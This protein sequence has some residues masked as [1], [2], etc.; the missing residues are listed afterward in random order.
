M[1][2]EGWFQAAIMQ[3]GGRD[4]PVLKAGPF[5]S[6]ITKDTYTE[7]GYKV[8][9][10]Q[11]VLSGNLNAASYY[12][13]KDAYEK[14]GSCSVQAGDILITMM[15][16]VG[17]IL[18]VP[19][20]AEPGVINP[21]L[22][23]ISVDKSRVYPNFLAR[24]LRTKSIQRLLQRRAHGGTMPGLNAKAIGSIRLDFPSLPEQRRIAEILHI[25]DLG[26]FT[27]EALI[28]NAKAHKKALMQSLL[29]SQRRL[30]GFSADWK[31]KS[32]DD[33][34]AFRRG[35]G[36]SKD[37][38]T[39][40]GI[41]PCILYGELYTRYP[42]VIENVVGRT[43]SN[44]G[45]HSKAGDILIPASTTTTG[46]DLANATA[47]LES[48][49]LLSGDINVLRAKDVRQSAPFFA[50]L[51]THTMKYKIASRAQGVTII[52]LYGSDLKPLK[53][54]VPEPDEQHAIADVIMAADKKIGGLQ[55]QLNA[56]RQEKSALMQQLLTGKRRVKVD[57]REDA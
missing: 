24:V 18:E 46:I 14:I 19:E 57:K 37:A 6:A 20:G 26:I 12:I 27:I 43:N 10:Q 32:L 50:Y 47:L 8:Y 44:E 15:G 54:S 33:L 30:P 31:E 13:S 34:F 49:V 4:R 56:V 5:G 11:E 40:H 45:F 2:P 38:V 53:V 3:L 25:W 17:R 41:R 55:S 29:T 22:M 7:T 23:R 36:L 39:P 35:Q 21:R 9:G 48:D 28:A 16:T 42:E 52:H 1:I 51:L